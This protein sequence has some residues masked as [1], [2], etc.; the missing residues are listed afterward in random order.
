MNTGASVKHLRAFIA[1]A[2]TSSFTRGAELVHL[3]QSSVTGLI[4]QLEESLNVRLFNRTSRTVELSEAGHDLLPAACK[5]VGE[6]D[7]LVQDMR[8]HGALEKGIVRVYTALSAM[9][10]MVAPAIAQFAQSY[11]SIRIHV[12]DGTF[13]P[14]V[15]AV[16]AGDVDFGIT[17]H[18]TETRGLRYEPLI[19][20]Q[21]G[22][23][24]SAADAIATADSPIKWSD[25]ADRKIVDLPQ[26]VGSH[27]FFRQ[28]H[29][30]PTSVLSPFYEVSSAGCQEALVRHSLGVA[31]LPSLSTKRW[32]SEATRFVVLHEPLIERNLCVV[33][34]DD[35]DLS[36]A[37]EMIK[38]YII[39]TATH[40]R[41][42]LHP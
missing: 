26:N 40:L 39:T 22:A 27:A 42:T 31:I 1:V 25:L 29:Q 37:A 2:H 35:R 23:L 10:T 33:V 21:Y 3:T 8:R 9:E 28:Y 15:D 6:F 38:K 30:V 16:L 41:K 32:L 36:P 4:A 12:Q 20:D 13:R 14:I 7:R 19:T 5:L 24:V 17:T 18:W 11:P 34:R